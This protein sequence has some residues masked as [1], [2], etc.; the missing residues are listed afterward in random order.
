MLQKELE[1]SAHNLTH[2]V[3][4]IHFEPTITLG[5]LVTIA[6]IAISVFGVWHKMDLNI[7]EQRGMIDAL[8]TRVDKLETGLFNILQKLVMDDSR[9]K[10]QANNVNP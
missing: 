8:N 2:L 10:Q 3:K 5:T 1:Q 4:R 7:H 6:S 9:R